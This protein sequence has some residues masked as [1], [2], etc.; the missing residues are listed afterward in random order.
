[1]SKPSKNVDEKT[2]KIVELCREF[3]VDDKRIRAKLRKMRA[4]DDAKFDV[5]R[6]RVKNDDESNAKW[7][8]RMSQRDAIIDVLKLKMKND[9]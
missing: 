3:D 4:N 8:Y 2:F 9:A 5:V 1:M 6:A 7:I